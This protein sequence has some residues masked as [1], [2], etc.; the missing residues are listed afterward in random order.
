MRKE[1]R[2]GWNGAGGP[3]VD[4]LREPGVAVLVL[5]QALALLPARRQ[6]A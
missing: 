5:P 6:A 3:V 1:E 2:G 4:A